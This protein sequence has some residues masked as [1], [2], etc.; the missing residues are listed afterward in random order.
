MKLII[1]GFF[2]GVVLAVV[3]FSV[4]QSGMSLLPSWHGFSDAPELIK[5]SEDKASPHIFS[6]STLER[7]YL[8]NTQGKF[9][10]DI[11]LQE[12]EY[13]ALSG[14]N[15]YYAKFSKLGSTI[16]FFGINDQPYWQIEAIQYPYI[17][18]TGSTCLL[19]VADLNS[20]HIMD[21]NGIP[22][23]A[24]TVSGKMC[25]DIRFSTNDFSIIG[26]LSS[27]YYILDEKGNLVLEGN[28]PEGTVVKTVAISKQAKFCAVHYGD[29][30][31]D[32]VRVIDLASKE[33]YEA[34]LESVYKTKNGMAVTDD[35]SLY[36]ADS[37]HF[38]LFNPKGKETL[39][40]EIEPQSYGLAK[41]SLAEK[42]VVFSYRTESKK[43]AL[44]I[45]TTDGT[46]LA[47]K[48]FED[49]SLDNTI[50]GSVILAKGTK[51]L[52]AWKFD[53]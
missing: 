44:Y 25:S 33:S 22:T 10:K 29:T 1:F 35:G 17:S 19:L 45:F 8:L 9:I 40:Y 28:A 4:S 7:S 11:P 3:P 51:S 37:L 24:K 26:F 47:K 42:L 16:A 6:Y 31:K 41:V 50:A 23:G 2:I 48:M 14:D 5:A 53:Y 36:V 38:K 21:K 52:A 49:S 13:I 30:E 32:T 27:H 15:N 46:L 39:S 20:V 34:A 18:Y 43:S 12:N